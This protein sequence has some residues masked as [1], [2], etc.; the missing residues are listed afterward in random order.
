M[1]RCNR[2]M[3]LAADRRAIVAVVATFL[4]AS[5][6]PAAAHRI[7]AALT[8]VQLGEDGAV[9]VTHRLYAHDVERALSLKGDPIRDAFAGVESLARAALYVDGGFLLETPDGQ[10]ADLQLLGAETEG[11][12][13]YVYAEGVFE[14]PP[15]QLRLHATMLFDVLDDQINRVNVAF[16]VG[17]STVDFREGEDA[18]VVSPRSTGAAP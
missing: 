11:E 18:D 6:K 15:A 17:V 16:P 9:Q 5:G 4:C 12:F 3:V 1:R 13:L 8:T 14:T 2:A 10:D 7:H